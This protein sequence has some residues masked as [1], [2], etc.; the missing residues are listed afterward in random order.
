MTLN[1][2]KFKT[3]LKSKM[4]LVCVVTVTIYCLRPILRYYIFYLLLYLIIYHR[5]R[6]MGWDRQGQCKLYIVTLGQVI[7]NYILRGDF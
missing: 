2:S 1:N 6:D 3:V 5:G 7:K 4:S